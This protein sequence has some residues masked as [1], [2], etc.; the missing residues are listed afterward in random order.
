MMSMLTTAIDQV[1]TVFS[2][3]TFLDGVQW[4]GSVLSLVA[5]YMIAL[6]RRVGYAFCL[7]VIANGCWFWFGWQT[8][9]YPMLLMQ[10]GFTVSSLLGIWTWL[11]KPRFVSSAS[12]SLQAAT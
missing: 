10:S 11:V 6:N 12:A 8:Q 9:N 2:T 5:T 4:V 3:M 7:Y 1:V